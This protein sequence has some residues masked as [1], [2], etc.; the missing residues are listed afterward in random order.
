MKAVL[1]IAVLMTGLVSCRTSPVG[2]QA[3]DVK[4]LRASDRPQQALVADMLFEEF[5]Y[6]FAPMEPES[7]LAWPSEGPCALGQY[8]VEYFP[9]RVSGEDLNGIGSF[10]VGGACGGEVLVLEITGVDL[11]GFPD[12]WRRQ[13]EDER[14]WL[15][16]EP[17]NPRWACPGPRTFFFEEYEPETRQGL[18]RTFPVFGVPSGVVETEVERH[19]QT[20]ERLFPGE[21]SWSPVAQVVT[22]G[23]GYT[24]L[25]GS[26]LVRGWNPDKDSGF[27]LAV[28]P[29]SGSLLQLVHWS[30]CDRGVEP[31]P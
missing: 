1:C 22:R 3:V 30:N 2:G 8:E 7:V 18:Q 31:F 23:S 26:Y 11:S 28:D 9:A 24:T 6:L 15:I 14:I 4:Q 19:R 17:E 25:P 16:P 10:F 29:V 13:L 20:A 12:E 27:S 5:G 21:Y